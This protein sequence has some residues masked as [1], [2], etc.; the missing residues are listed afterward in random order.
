MVILCCFKKKLIN[1]IQTIWYLFHS[2]LMSSCSSWLPSKVH[3]TDLY[4]LAQNNRTIPMPN[5]HL[6]WGVYWVSICQYNPLYRANWHYISIV[7]IQSPVARLRT[8]L[9][10]LHCGGCHLSS[11]ALA[12][13]M[14][15]PS[16]YFN[17][18]NQNF[19]TYPI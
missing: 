13:L 12:N 10:P 3:H 14:V 17:Y 19:K 6:V 15:G 5:R 18:S 2:L 7:P 4:H 1:R 8:L 16:S 11:D 9:P